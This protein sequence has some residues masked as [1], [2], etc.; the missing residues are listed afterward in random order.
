MYAKLNHLVL[1]INLGNILVWN[2][3]YDFGDGGF[4]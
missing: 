4:L 3:V 2:A 1:R